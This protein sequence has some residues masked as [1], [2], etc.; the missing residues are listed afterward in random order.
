MKDNTT[1]GAKY[2]WYNLDKMKIRNHPRR[3]THCVI[4]YQTNRY[5]EH[6]LQENAITVF[7]P[8]LY[9]SLPKYLRDIKRVETEKIKFVLDE[10]LELIHPEPKMLN[11]VTAA[12]SNKI[13]DKLSHPMA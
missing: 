8:R 6:Y 3:G 10:F 1:F 4:E 5:P 12:R 2:R 9:N 11:Y 13:L 7:V